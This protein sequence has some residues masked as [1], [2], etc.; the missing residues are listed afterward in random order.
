MT[1]AIL[2]VRGSHSR[3]SEQLALTSNAQPMNVT[4]SCGFPTGHET[5]SYITIDMG[6]TKVR[7]CNVVLTDGKG[8][9]D[10]VQEK[11]VMPEGLKKS[12]AEMLWEFL[13][14]CTAKFINKHKPS[15]KEALPLSFTFSF[16][17]TQPNIRSG[18]LQRWTKDFDVDGV[19][20]EDIVPQLEEAFRKR[21]CCCINFV[22]TFSNE[23]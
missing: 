8:G 18:I 19:E 2:Y 6:G 3:F 11:F 15:T 12:N 20:G 17:L 14:D 13:A 4:W 1:G 21:V 23:V 10:L 7:V 5:G 16:P 22:S 9:V